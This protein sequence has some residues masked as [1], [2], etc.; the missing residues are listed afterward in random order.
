MRVRTGATYE[1]RLVIIGHMSK[2]DQSGTDVVIV[3]GGI[4]GVEALLAL[5]D[6]A[7]DR[8]RLTLIADQPDFLYK[9]LL[10]EEP[11]G[12]DP[13][14]R[15]ELAPVLEE[16][17]G[18]FIQT[19]L[20]SVDSEERTIRL[21]DGSS[22]S[23]DNLVV[24]VGGK[25]SPAY[26]DVVT[27][28]SPGSQPTVEEVLTKAHVRGKDR[29]AFIVPPGVAWSLPLYEIALLTQRRARER[30]FKELQIRFLT[31]EPAPLAVFGPAAS[32][33][34]AELLE[35]RNIEFTGNALVHQEDGE[36]VTAPGGEVLD[37][38]EVVALPTMSGPA[39][40]GL[41]SDDG[42]FIPVD[43]HGLVR[44]LDDVYAAG[45]GTT[46]PV[47]QG[48]LATQ[49]ADAVAEHIAH[50]LGAAIEVEP[51]KPV[52]RGKLLTGGES[53]HMRSDV[54]G[55]GGEGET[56]LDSL[57]WPSHKISGRY[58]GPWLYQDGSELDLRLQG[59]DVELP[60]EPPR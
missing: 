43:D 18:E 13:A 53:L 58:L 37:E 10:V 44:G 4:A 55:G 24:C 12:L 3:G 49:Q 9:P 48:G 30:D 41:P 23:F 20:T 28:P 39:I 46:F 42:G 32:A 59:Y 52:L 34:V 54:A 22:R 8:A 45:D 36:L 40:P 57:W 7:G 47:K 38:A 15:R 27:F 2:Q 50:R 25:F 14:L 5:H 33:E 17:D 26:E 21:G 29:I 16:F 60:T 51:F 19:E 35:A 31:P 1:F 56:S 11:F 6:L